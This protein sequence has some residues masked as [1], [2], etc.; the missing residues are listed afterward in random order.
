MNN[1][2]EKYLDF[3][4]DYC[5][6]LLIAFVGP[7]KAEE[8]DENTAVV[9]TESEEYEL[10]NITVTAEKQ[11]EDVQE[12]PVSITVLDG[13]NIEDQNIESLV[14][15]GDYVPGLTIFSNGASGMNSPSLRGLH[16]PAESLT[17][18]TG[19]FLTVSLFYRLPDLKI[20]CLISKELR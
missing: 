6:F 9:A 19:L 20:A 13:Q 10:D 5:V 11:E 15:L 8:S 1:V 16:A 12:V 17:V 18:S 14:E 2:A 7:T 3:R 4:I